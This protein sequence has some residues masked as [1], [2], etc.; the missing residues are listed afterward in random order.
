MLLRVT[1]RLQPWHKMADTAAERTAAEIAAVQS[2]IEELKQEV[3]AQAASGDKEKELLLL[4]QLAT[5]REEKLL[6]MKQQA[7]APCSA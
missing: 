1:G 7:G 4:R 5:L 6:L 3:K 2:E